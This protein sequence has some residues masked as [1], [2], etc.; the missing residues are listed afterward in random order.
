MEIEHLSKESQKLWHKYVP[1]KVKVQA[2]QA[3][4][5]TGLQALDQAELA[6]KAIAD[7]G[8]F[9]VTKTTGAVHANPLIK[10]EKEARAYFLK[11]ITTLNLHWGE[12][13]E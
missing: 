13:F 3:L 12:P 6:R 11:A 2:G 4:F 10:V 8:L 1:K 7:Q 9:T 5:L